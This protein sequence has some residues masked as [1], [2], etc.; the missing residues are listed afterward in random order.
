MIHLRRSRRVARTAGNFRD[1]YP[2]NSYVDWTCL[3]GFNWGSTN[4]S[5]G[6]QSFEHVFSSTYKEVQKIAPGKPMI[7][8]ET[9]ADERGGSKADWIRNALA[10]IPQKFPKIRGLVWFDED[11]QG[12]KWPIE[13][14]KSSERAFQQSIAPKL[15]RPNIYSRLL[16]PK[17][18]PPTWGSPPS[19]PLETPPTITAGS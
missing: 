17:I 11:S 19:E 6:W 14:S 5:S 16:G 9:A 4:K 8:G 2:G 13:S 7:I 12:M 3:D 10:T 18:A 15:Y 1:L